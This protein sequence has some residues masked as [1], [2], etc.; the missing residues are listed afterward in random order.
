MTKVHAAHR[1]SAT[2]ANPKS[3]RHPSASRRAL[4][5]VAGLVVFLVMLI[6]DPP[7]AMPE[8]AW[9]AA[10]VGILMAIWWILEAIPIPATALVPLAL[11]PFLGI[12][13]IK[14]AAAPYANPLIFLFLGG[15]V[16]AL[17]MERWNLHRRIALNILRVVGSNPAA[18]VGGFMVATAFLSMWVS[19]TATATMMLPIGLSVISL[20]TAGSLPG[21]GDGRGEHFT[22]ALLLGIAYSASI[23][24]I[25]TLIGTPPNALLAG[26]F[27]EAYGVGI[28]FADWMMMAV[29]LEII[30]LVIAW[31]VL[32]RVV[33]PIRVKEL[34]GVE[35]MIG[36]ELDKLG[37]VSRGEKLIAAVFV[38][39]A[40]LWMIRP[41]LNQWLP[42]M[43]ISDPGIAVIAALVVFVIPVE[44][45][46][47]VFLLDWTA[48]QGLPWGVL[49]LF[50]GGLSLGAAINGTGLS[51]WIAEAMS[52]ASGWPT[53]GLLLAVVAVVM[54]ISH[55]TSNTA[56]AA[57]FLPL[58][59][60]LAVSLGENPLLLTI[61]MVLA[62][63]CV[64]MMPVATPP[65][66]IV[67]ASGELTV[68]QMAKAGFLINVLSLI[69]I[70]LVAYTLMELAFSIQAGVIPDWAASGPHT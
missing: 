62:A 42:G 9:L 60:A 15:F 31:L 37:P 69:L 47:R 1:D 46:N 13:P 55:M 64:F 59:A 67:F 38:T 30:L 2:A 3:G 56:T 57:A 36:R 24:G 63:S 33:F 23:G 16:I 41:L 65:N 48:T 4:G 61:P 35:E 14:A 68:P 39:T 7:G 12:Q 20:V 28:G 11:F 32:T 43:N 66:A 18:L 49:I 52:G 25:G 21:Q 50:G 26:Y 8:K 5:L 53:F 51:Q 58:T 34:T 45:K 19:N 40:L 29:P 44:P 22:P 27:A 17:A 54:V 6:M 70:L 10:A